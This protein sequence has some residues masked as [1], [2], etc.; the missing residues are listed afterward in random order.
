MHKK[1][2]IELVN[3]LKITGGARI[4]MANATWPFATLKVNKDKFELNASILGKLVF[5]PSNI[6]SIDPYT[7]IPIVGQGIKINHNVESYNQKVIFWTFKNPQTVINQIEQTG[8]LNNQ[9]ELKTDSIVEIRNRQKNGGFPVKKSVTIGAVV[10]WNLLFLIDFIPF[11]Q[12]KSEG[13]PIGNGVLMALGLLFFS[14]LL[15]LISSD[16]RRLI[17]KDGRTLEDITKFSIFIMI[18]SGIMM[19]SFMLMT[20]MTN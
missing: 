4:G 14:A 11:L 2:K 7:Q 6:K 9:Q 20:K 19:F 8:F 3:E 18:I 5:Q 17:L 15:S 13:L 1:T 10:I 12:G 16:F